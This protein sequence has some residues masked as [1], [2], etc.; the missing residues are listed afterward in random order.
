MP[1]VSLFKWDEQQKTDGQTIWNWNEGEKKNIKM[2]R[3]IRSL[4]HLLMTLGMCFTLNTN[5]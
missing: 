2:W 1:N 5:F 3:Q 4:Q